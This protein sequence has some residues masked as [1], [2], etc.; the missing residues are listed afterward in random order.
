M[1]LLQSID[2][3]HLPA[4]YT[5]HIAL[6]RNVKNAAFLQQQLLAGNTEFEYGFIDA[7]VL[8][9]RVH[10]LAA[11]YRAVNDLVE[12]R[13][14]SRNVHSEIVFALSPN[15]NVSSSALHVPSHWR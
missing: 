2:L 8:V 5:L 7:S 6:Y 13:L 3:E 12:D 1:A 14:S 4:D 11:A 15:N 10:A 9:S